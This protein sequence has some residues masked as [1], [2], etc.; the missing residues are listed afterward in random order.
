MV[1]R[2]REHVQKALQRKGFRRSDNDHAK[3]TYFTLT[4]D[5]TSVWTKTSY[6]SSHKDLIDRR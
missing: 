6:G 4:G 1:P 3:F 5:K 2:K